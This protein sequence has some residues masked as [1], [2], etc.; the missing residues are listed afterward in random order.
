MRKSL[1]VLLICIVQKGIERKQI[2]NDENRIA[3]VILRKG[4]TIILKNGYE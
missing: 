3:S 2:H 4:Q 1:T